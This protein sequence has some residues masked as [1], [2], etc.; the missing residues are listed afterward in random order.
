MDDASERPATAGHHQAEVRIPAARTFGISGVFDKRRGAFEMTQ[1]VPPSVLDRTGSVPPAS[2]T[3]LADHIIGSAVVLR[4]GADERMVTGHIHLEF[5]KPLPPEVRSFQGTTDDLHL[6]PLGAFG[7][8]SIVTNNGELVALISSRFAI[9][10]GDRVRPGRKSSP[11]QNVVESERTMGPDPSI[12]LDLTASPLDT[13]LGTR[14]VARD[15]SHVRV[16]FEATNDLANDRG[17]LHG[18]VAALMADRAATLTLPTPNSSESPY[19]HTEMRVVFLR[20]LPTKGT[21]IEVDAAITHLGNSTA[22]TTAFVRDPNGR[23]AVQVD[24]IY[25]R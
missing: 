4:L 17:G 13:L 25:T 10:G 8:G 22:T 5:L 16:R 3:L 18:G 15:D 20:P 19:S 23:I 2:L 6:T 9:L 12:P 14:L 21:S 1:D 7:R 24:S 11:K